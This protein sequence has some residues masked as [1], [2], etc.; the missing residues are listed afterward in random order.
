MAV[1]KRIAT[2]PAFQEAVGAIGA[3][4]LQLVWHTNSA[5]LEPADIYEKVEFPVIIGLWHGQHFLAPFI[6]RGEADRAKVLI[7]RHRDGEINARAARRLGIGIIRGSGAHNREFARKGGASAFAEMLEALNQGYNVALTADIPKV[8]RVAGMGIVK[9]AQYSGRPIYPAAIASSRRKEF[10]NWDRTTINLPFGRVGI[11]AGNPVSVRATPTMPPWKRPGSSCR[12]N[13]TAPP[14]APT[15]SPTARGS[16]EK[17]PLPAGLIAYRL[18]S[19]ALAPLAPMFLARRLARGKENGARLGE[20]RGETRIKR[21]R[22]PLVWLHGASVGELASVL[23]LIE[24][25]AQRNV[26]VLVTTGTVSS[27]E[28]AGHRLP[29]G[30]IHQFVP[31]DVPRFVRGFLD[32]WRPDLVLF[33]ESDLWPNLMIEISERGVPMMLVNGRLSE[34]SLRRWRYLPNSIVNLLQRFDLCLAR[35]PA[36]AQRFGELGASQI[37]TTGDLKLDVP[38]PPADGKNLTALQ[39]AIGGRPVIAAASTHAGEEAAVIDAHAQLRG[40]FPGLLTLIAPRHPERGPDI[41]EIAAAAGLQAVLRSSGALPAP[42]TEIYVADTL[43]ELGIVYRVA[44][45]AFVGGSLVRHGGQNPIEA[46]K[47]GAAIL[48]GPHVWNFAE[49]YSALD[50]AQGAVPLSDARLL[51]AGFRALMA[52][53]AARARLTKAARAKVDEL[54]GALEKTLDALDPYL[55]KLGQRRRGRHA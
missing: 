25:I 23:P 43:G 21:P 30:V 13:S 3:W 33:V 15:R 32:H 10:D 17:K 47:L 19:A 35:T 54:S 6:K 52:Q 1:L 37:V 46:A 39:A 55:E 49:I 4:Y 34:R 40:V 42:A 14:R 24:R 45:A 27:S 9:L 29:G 31:L 44:P 5:R 41:A 36:D 8:A 22:G 7:S 11:V 38:A 50:Q 18:L 2:S 51:V 53:P 12:A 48:H 26:A 16:R 28:L 20:R